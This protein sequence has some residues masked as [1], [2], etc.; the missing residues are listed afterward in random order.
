ML[1]SKETSPLKTHFL[2]KDTSMNKP[3]RSSKP[4]DDTGELL[5]RHNSFSLITDS[6]R[7]RFKP[8]IKVDSKTDFLPSEKGSSRPAKNLNQK[9]DSNYGQFKKTVVKKR[10]SKMLFSQLGFAHDNRPSNRMESLLNSRKI[11]ESGTINIKNTGAYLMGRVSPHSQTSNAEFRFDFLDHSVNGPQS[12]TPV[13]SIA[14]MRKK[15]LVMPSLNSRIVD[16]S[17]RSRLGSK[18]KHTAEDLNNS[19]SSTSLSNLETNMTSLTSKMHATMG[20]LSQFVS[21]FKADQQEKL[22]RFEAMARENGILRE[23]LKA[24]ERRHS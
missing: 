8:M 24:L 3:L 7:E 19:Q 13:D 20:R 18:A 6:K 12:P 23:K 14:N 2:G 21:T 22:V 1:H 15:S 9:L 11:N 17:L 4:S 10:S 16:K 5:M